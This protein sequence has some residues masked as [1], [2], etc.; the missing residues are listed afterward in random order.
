METE[1]CVKGWKHEWNCVESK[2]GYNTLFCK[3]CGKSMKSKIE[4]N[5]KE[6][7]KNESEENKLKDF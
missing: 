1:E 3:H 5:N 7:Q 6:V 2:D 4:D